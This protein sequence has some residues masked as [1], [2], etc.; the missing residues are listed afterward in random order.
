MEESGE[1]GENT[2]EATHD[3][4]A[5]GLMKPSVSGHSQLDSI[6]STAAKVCYDTL[7]NDY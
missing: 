2:G 3:G 4:G 1:V 6:P 5:G 7:L